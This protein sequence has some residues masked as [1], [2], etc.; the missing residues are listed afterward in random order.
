MKNAHESHME[1]IAPKNRT[2]AELHRG[3]S[4]LFVAVVYVIG[5]GAA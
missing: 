2:D 4:L 5:G 1:S 3:P